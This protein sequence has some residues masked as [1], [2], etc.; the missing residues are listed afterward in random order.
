M[1]YF[2]PSL[3]PLPTLA[4]ATIQ[5]FSFVKLL[6]QC[7]FEVTFHKHQCYL[8]IYICFDKTHPKQNQSNFVSKYCQQY[9][10]ILNFSR[11]T[12]TSKPAKNELD[13]CV[14]HR[15]GEKY[16]VWHSTRC[17]EDG[18]FFSLRRIYRL[19]TLVISYC[20]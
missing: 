6:S 19:R 11:S 13:E 14:V 8:F 12:E 1:R 17:K 5:F 10:E 3:F 7:I 18:E 16:I 9:C 15:S 20:S 4:V 2:L